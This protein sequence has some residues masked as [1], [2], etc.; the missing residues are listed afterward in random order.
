VHFARARGNEVLG[1]VIND[2]PAVPGLAEQTSPPVI[3]R[4]ARAPILAILE[5]DPEVEVGEGNLGRIPE[6]FAQSRLLDQVMWS[7]R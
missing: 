7:A 1:I 4:L 6:L 5:H 2:F 3:E